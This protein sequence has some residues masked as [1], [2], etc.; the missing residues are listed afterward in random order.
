MRRPVFF[1]ACHSL[2]QLIGVHA[3]AQDQRGCVEREM[4]D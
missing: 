4:Y 1:S 2:P 3:G